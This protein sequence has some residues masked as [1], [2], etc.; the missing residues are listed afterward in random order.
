MRFIIWLITQFCVHEW[1]ENENV[2]FSYSKDGEIRVGARI[3]DCCE[4]CTMHRLS[5]K[6]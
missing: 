2:G 5:F 6:H 4:K 1:R 3:V